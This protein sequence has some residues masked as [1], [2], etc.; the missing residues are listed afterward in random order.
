M[1]KQPSDSCILQQDLNR[2]T[3]WSK[4][5][6]LN[7][8]PLKCKVM[9]LGRGNPTFYSMTDHISGEV[10]ELFL[11]EEGKDLGIWIASN[12]KSSLHCFRTAIRTATRTTQ[13]LGQLKRSFKFVSKQ[14][15]G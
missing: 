14:S 12:L 11:V 2:I 15:W 7:F 5:W 6:L 3:A 10:V 1:I 9:H 13:M 4:E 8:N